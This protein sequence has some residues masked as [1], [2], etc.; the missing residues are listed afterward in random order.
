M[1]NIMKGKCVRTFCIMVFFFL[2]LLALG[3]QTTPCAAG[4]TTISLGGDSSAAVKSD[5]SLWCWGY[6]TGQLGDGT[7]T[8]RYTPVKILDNVKSVCLGT[9]H[10]AAIKADGTLWCWGNNS[11]GQLGDGTY[12]DKTKPVKV[13][14]NVKAV[15]LGSFHSA[16]L[17][18]D[19]T[20]WC[21]GD[22]SKYQIGDGTNFLRSKP[23][24]IMDGI[25]SISLGTYHSAAVKTDGTLWCWGDN[26]YG[27]L[28]DGTLLSRNKPVKITDSVS[29]VDLDFFYSAIIK[30][31]KSVWCWGRNNY[32]QIGDGTTTDR[33]K[34][35]KIMTNVSTVS[36][37]GWNSA[38]VKTDGSLWCWGDNSNGQLGIGT[39]T[40]ST[41]PIK[42]M[43]NMQS[44]SLGDKH[45]A[46][47]NINGSLYCWGCNSNGQ[48]GDGTTLDR[49]KPVAVSM[50]NTYT[51]SYNAN[52]GSGAP[53]AQ[54]KKEGT[55]ITLSSTKP[56][57]SGYTFLGWSDNKSASAAVYDA[58]GRYTADRNVTLYAVWKK[59]GAKNN[60]TI[61]VKSQITK[62]YKIGSTFSLGAKAK[63][64][65]SYSSNAKQVITVS[66]AGKVTVK[67][68]G[69]AVVR[70][71]AAATSNYNSAVKNVNIFIVPAKLN[72][73]ASQISTSI[74]RLKW[75]R[76]I[77][78][79]GY[80]LNYSKNSKFPDTK[81]TKLGTSNGNKGVMHNLKT[82]FGKTTYYLRIRSYK[83]VNGTMLYGIW[84]DVKKVSVR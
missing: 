1:T 61:D 15:S 7:K 4:I 13:M 84:S 29:T 48:I 59:T 62:P 45:S 67:G 30:T 81:D 70:I 77:T 41:K 60:Q 26:S 2:G 38:V 39:I 73:T 31:D 17:K 5:G 11:K 72:L 25:K 35:V 50:L 27:A 69:K 34:P 82:V 75:N 3:I 36:L 32:G 47:V 74:I 20:L 24:K 64:K 14:D 46:S 53:P 22:N 68:Y 83:K 16:A 54:S 21:W 19:G 56:K 43:D 18:T 55:I 42:I 6:N 52:G 78:V 71:V 9:A 12:T 65:L 80:Q 28:G 57:R 8:D 44:V 10:S 63:G 33:Y 51:V 58:G 76:D 40:P 49:Y 66:S 37:G 23:V 79:D